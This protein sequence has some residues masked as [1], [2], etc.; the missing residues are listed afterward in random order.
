MGAL[1]TQTAISPTTC[2]TATAVCQTWSTAIR[3]SQRAS[4]PKADSKTLEN[5]HVCAHKDT[6]ITFDKCYTDAFVH[7]NTL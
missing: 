1:I 5:T 6:R 3:D 2:D 4:V 7:L